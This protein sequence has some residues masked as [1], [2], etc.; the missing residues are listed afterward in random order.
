MSDFSDFLAIFASVQNQR[1]ASFRRRST[2]LNYYR[3]IDESRGSLLILTI[4]LQTVKIPKN[5]Q[6]NQSRF[7]FVETGT[8]RHENYDNTYLKTSSQNDRKLTLLRAQQIIAECLDEFV[9]FTRFT[10]LYAG[11]QQLS[12][13]P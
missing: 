11:T 10:V 2:I 8:K 6:M 7:I 5:E 9:N 3:A 12:I 4:A 1:F 13:N